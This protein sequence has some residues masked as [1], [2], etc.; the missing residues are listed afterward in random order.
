MGFDVTCIGDC[1]KPRGLA[2]AI[3]EGFEAALNLTTTTK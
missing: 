2:E 1:K 3:S